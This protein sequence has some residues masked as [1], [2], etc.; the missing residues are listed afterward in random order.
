MDKEKESS[1]APPA[2]AVPAHLPYRLTCPTCPTCPTWVALYSHRPLSSQVGERS[3]IKRKTGAPEERDER[4]EQ[5]S[6]ISAHRHRTRQSHR[7]LSGGPE[8]EMVGG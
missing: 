1:G 8:R 5:A 2:R 7:H 6:G 4:H 3:T